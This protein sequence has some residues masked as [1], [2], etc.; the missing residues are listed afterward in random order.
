MPLVELD[1]LVCH[2]ST[3]HIVLSLHS[4][5]QSHVVGPHN[6]NF[7][8]V[9]DN[10]SFFH[11]GTAENHLPT[12]PGASVHEKEF[13]YTIPQTYE[14]EVQLGSDVADMIDRSRH[15]NLQPDHVSIHDE[16]F[17]HQSYVVDRT[18]S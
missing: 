17:P 10:I 16:Q 4:V 15:N 18:Y 3:D 8:L 2:L 9:L 13:L 12:V 7:R 14:S 6:R 1:Y 5:P 11:A